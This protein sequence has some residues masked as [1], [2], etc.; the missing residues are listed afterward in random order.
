MVAGEVYDATHDVVAAMEFIGDT[1][2][3]M[4]DR[5]IKKR[6]ERTRT[7]ALLADLRAHLALQSI[8]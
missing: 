1:S 2:I 4:A 3:R 8:S 6:L 5:Y 7:A